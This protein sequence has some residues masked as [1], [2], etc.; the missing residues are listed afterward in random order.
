MALKTNF[1]LN[2]VTIENA[3]LRIERLWGNS[4]EGFEALVGVYTVTQNEELE[5]DVYRK[6]IEFNLTPTPYNPNENPYVTLYNKL[7][8]MFGGEEA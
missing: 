7:Q 5:T 2:G 8:E 4:K 1:N 3:Y 6:I